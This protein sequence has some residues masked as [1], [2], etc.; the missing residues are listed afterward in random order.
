MP[1][2]ASPGDNVIGTVARIVWS[3]ARERP[4]LTAAGL[5]STLVTPLQ[6]IVVPH[7][8]GR[9][10]NAIKE[11]GDAAKKVS[12]HAEF[13]QTSRAKVLRA[14]VAVGVAIAAIQAGYVGVDLVD[15]KLFGSMMT[16]VRRHMLRCVLDANDTAQA[17]ELETGELMSKFTKTP[18]TVANWFEAVKAVIPNVLVYVFAVAYFWWTDPVLGFALLCGVAVTFAAVVVN[19]RTC[20]DV[21]EGRDV[22]FNRVNE[23]IDELL[24]NLP[25][26][27]SSGRKRVEQAE[28]R[29]DE[30]RAERLYFDTYLCATG[31]KLWMVPAALLMVGTML[32]RSLDLLSDGRMTIGAFVSVFSIFLYMMTSMLRIVQN[33]R[34]A[35]Y[36]WGIIKTSMGTLTCAD[37]ADSGP[38]GDSSKKKAIGGGGRLATPPVPGAIVELRQASYAHVGAARPA[39]DRVSMSVREGERVAVIGRMGSGKSTLARLVLR[40]LEPTGGELLL[41]GVPYRDLPVDA[42]RATFGYVPQNASLFDRS[43]LA[44]A[45]Y[46]V[47]ARRFGARPPEEAVWAAARELGFDDVLAALPAGLRTDA[48]KGGSR[49]SGGQRQAVWLVRMLLL[50]PAV[51]VLDEPTSAMD[52]DSR[53]KVAAALARFRTV[54]FVTHD[55]DFVAAAAT[56][57]VLLVDGRVSDAEDI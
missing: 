2:D 24:R 25:A 50:G 51:L 17:G 41:R 9:V 16:H 38:I 7:L 45:C 43:V 37:G 44:N 4:G 8:T 21:S 22:A 13:K 11:A 48:G 19:L 20:A 36:Y 15:A 34:A 10:V 46:G 49:L 35:V 54:V 56:R 27:F 12:D 40:L 6:D 26:V 14:F 5:A 53:E 47:P 39:L 33:S 42:V 52:P 3:F 30:E 31:V 18:L 57:T 32:W 29:P 1:S 55:M 28:L 23:R